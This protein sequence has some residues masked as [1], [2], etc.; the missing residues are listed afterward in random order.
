MSIDLRLTAIRNSHAKYFV[1]MANLKI[2]DC[3][4][5]LKINSLI[6]VQRSLKFEDATSMLYEHQ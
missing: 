3:I 6:S 4:L 5:D 2:I 1:H